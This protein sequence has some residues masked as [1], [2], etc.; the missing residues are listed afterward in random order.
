MRHAAKLPK[1]EPWVEGFQLASNV[2][3]SGSI[4][5]RRY[6]P[7]IVFPREAVRGALQKTIL[8]RRVIAEQIDKA[9]RVA[10]EVRPEGLQQRG[11]YGKVPDRL[12]KL[13][14]TGPQLAA[15]TLE[16]GP[17]ERN[18]VEITRPYLLGFLYELR[19]A[20]HLFHRGKGLPFIDVCPGTLKE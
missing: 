13:A 4:G 14:D 16:G 10:Q 11:R 19:G 20:K 18:S 6:G 8:A 17:G 2:S 15:R 12:V 7:R 1:L 9:G 3:H 5:G